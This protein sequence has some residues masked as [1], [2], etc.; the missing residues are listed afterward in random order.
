M[1][2]SRKSGFHLLKLTGSRETR[3]VQ[4]CLDP[5]AG[6]IHI[7][8]CKPATCFDFHVVV[9]TTN[10]K[11][12]VY[13]NDE[14]EVINCHTFSTTVMA[15]K[16][17]ANY[18]F[19]KYMLCT[20]DDGSAHVLRIDRVSL[21]TKTGNAALLTKIHLPRYAETETSQPIGMCIEGLNNVF[22]I[23]TNLRYLFLFKWE[24]EHPKVLT[25]FG[26]KILPTDGVSSMA[27]M[28]GKSILA[29]GCFDGIVR[30]FMYPEMNQIS[31]I[32][33][34]KTQINTMLFLNEKMSHG[35]RDYLLVG[36]ND[37][38]ISVWTIPCCKEE[39]ILSM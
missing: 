19:N 31:T 38:G 35:G 8:F 33:Y 28:R 39:D 36:A 17:M 14:K 13:C 23:G 15:M 9:P 1:A 11:I 25:P 32:H 37:S 10:F 20:T 34:H 30:L 5:R 21:S 18:E 16:E 27:M 26:K 29:V 6:E 2:H 24:K 22:V 3:A 4:R 12:G 7:G